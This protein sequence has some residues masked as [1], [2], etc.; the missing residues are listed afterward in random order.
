MMAFLDNHLLKP[1]LHRWRFNLKTGETIEES[2]DD[3]VLEFGA[4]NQQYA[5]AQNIAL[6]TA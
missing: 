4:I 2:L 6:L 1:R 5:C 3:K